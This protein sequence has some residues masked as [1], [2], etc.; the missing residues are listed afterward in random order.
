LPVEEEIDAEQQSNTAQNKRDTGQT[1]TG[2][3]DLPE[4][5]DSVFSLKEYVAVAARTRG[6]C[7]WKS[8]S[9]R[10]AESGTTRFG[11]LSG[12]ASD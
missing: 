2:W 1:W 11:G 12:R 5:G 8:G 10:E 7:D 3:I 9:S 6:F 4:H